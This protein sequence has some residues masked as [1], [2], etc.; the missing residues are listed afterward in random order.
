VKLIL[1]LSLSL[2]HPKN[3]PYFVLTKQSRLKYLKPKKNSVLEAKSLPPHSF[4]LSLFFFFI[5]RN[6][7]FSNFCVDFFPAND[8]KAFTN[9]SIC[10][11]C[12]H[13]LTHIIHFMWRVAS[14]IEHEMVYKANKEM[15]NHE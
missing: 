3:F 5:T 7:K 1:D 6:K 15:K 10:F 2:E 9:V 13:S 4:S 14:K 11:L 8:R 12:S